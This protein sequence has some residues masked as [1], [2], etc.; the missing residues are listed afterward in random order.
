MCD[1][2]EEVEEDEQGHEIAGPSGMQKLAAVPA[3]V[4]THT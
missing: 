1:K 2:P 4:E 3:Q